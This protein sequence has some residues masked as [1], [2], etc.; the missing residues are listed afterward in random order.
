[1]VGAMSLGSLV[2]AALGGA[3]VGLAPGGLLKLVL[4]AVL[5]IAAAKTMRTH[6]A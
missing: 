4:G 1:M 6:R 2:G 3:L 5:L